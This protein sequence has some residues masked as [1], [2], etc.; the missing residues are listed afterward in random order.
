MWQDEDRAAL[1]ALELESGGRVRSHIVEAGHWV[2][3]DDL[4]GVKRA[5]APS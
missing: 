3:V 1:G 2:H 4:E 5:L